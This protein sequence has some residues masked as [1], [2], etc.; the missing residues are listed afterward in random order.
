MK[1]TA[2]LKMVSLF[3]SRMLRKKMTMQVM[4]FPFDAM[5]PKVKM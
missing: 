3:V 1:L 2:G 4:K 5:M